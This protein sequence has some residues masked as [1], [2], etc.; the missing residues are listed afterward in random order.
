V[1]HTFDNMEVV[2]EREEYNEESEDERDDS[3]YDKKNMSTRMQKIEMEE[4]LLDPEKFYYISVRLGSVY[5]VCV[6][7]NKLINRSQ[8]AKDVNNDFIVKIYIGKGQ[9]D[10]L[11]LGGLSWMSKSCFT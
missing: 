1:I 7:S 3:Y 11:L 5:N 4:F 9:K 10:T 8:V 6:S 2:R